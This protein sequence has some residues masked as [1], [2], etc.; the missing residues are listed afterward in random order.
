[1]SARTHPCLL[2]LL[3]AGVVWLLGSTASDAQTG[4]LRNWVTPQEVLVLFNASWPDED[5]NHRSD[6]QDVAEYYAA[7]RGIP[8][9]HLLGLAVTDHEAK[10]DRLTYVDFFQRVL[11]PTRKRLA[12]LAA[13]GAHIHYLVICY[14]MPLVITTGLNGK[15]NEHPVWRPSDS[16]ASTRALTGWLVNIEENFE[17]GFDSR[18]GKP[19]PRGG[20]SAAP[21]SVPLGSVGQDITV[22]WLRG[23]F[24]RPA[25]L[26][27]FKALRWTSPAR[28][29]TYLVT[30]LGGETLEISLGL[31]DKAL[32]AERYL[33]NFAGRPAHPYYGRVWLD[34]NGGDGSGHRPSLITAA[35]W[36]KGLLPTSVFASVNRSQPWYQGRPWDVRMDNAES[37]IGSR[38]S[39]DWGRRSTRPRSPARSSAS[40][41]RPMSSRWRRTAI[42]R[43]RST[44]RWERLSRPREGDGRRCSRSHRPPR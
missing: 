15:Q 37:E 43:L 19:G 41:R 13:R 16:D 34:H 30:H 38:M 3:A 11:V 31:I 36:F 21:G 2:G 24:D 18:T 12:E 4:A 42:P 10:P 7:R 6:S 25:A 27:S 44:F 1:M 33:Q 22:P 9:D 14:G 32:Y 17:A 29:E 26:S 20:K 23:A 8:R 35:L 5:G 40:T 39:K 28:S